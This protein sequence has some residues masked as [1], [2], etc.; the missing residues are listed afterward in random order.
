MCAVFGIVYGCGQQQSASTPATPADYEKTLRTQL[1]VGKTGRR[2]HHSGR[3][4]P[5]DA[6][7]RAVD[8][9]TSPSKAPAWTRACCRSRDRSPA[10]KV[11]WS[12]PSNFTIEDLAIEDTKGDALKVNEGSNIVIRRVRTEWTGGPNTKN[13]AYGI[14]PVMTQNMLI[15][16]SMAIG[17]SDAGIYVGQSQNVVIAQQPRRIQRGRHRDR[18]LDRRRRATTTSPPTTPAASWC[19]TCRT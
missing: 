16:G 1:E 7:P 11:C 15:E 8:A 3:H 4:V 17:A 5:D 2:D 10:P 18:E 6:Q 12:T 9:A 13:G 14:Y 19:S